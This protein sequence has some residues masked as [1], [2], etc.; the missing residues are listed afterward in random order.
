MTKPVDLVLIGAGQRGARAYAPYALQHPD[1][2]RFVAVA[3]PDPVRRERFAR[4]HGIPPERCFSDWQALLAQ[5]P[6]ADGALIC[7]QDR[8]HEA[9]AV[10]ALQAGYHVL[11]EKPMAPTLAACVRI[12]QA[13]EQSGRHLQVCHVMRYADFYRQLQRVVQ[14]GRLGEVITVDHRENVG[15]W[16]MAHSFVRGHWRR[17]D[18]SSPMI[19]AKCCHDLDLLYWTLGRPCRRLSAFGGLRHFRADQV[20]PE[21]PER[22]SDGCP[23]ERECPFSAIAIYVEGRPFRA[24]DDAGPP[25][26]YGPDRPPPWPVPVI[27]DDWSVAGR[28][29]AIRN[30]PWGRCV[31]RCD[32]DVVDHHVIAMEFDGGVSAT[33][34]MH[35]HSHEDYRS[36]R[37]DG[38]RATLR[39]RFGETAEMTVH[40]HAS[41]RVEPVLFEGAGDGHGG[42]D[43]GVMQSFARVLRGEEQPLTNARASLESHLMA[44]AAEA[45]RTSGEVVDL[46]DFR[47]QAEAAARGGSGM[48]SV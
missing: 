33:F 43:Q 1:Q 5:G 8:H 28:W 38:T 7:T 11:L 13:S 36:I 32:N 12:V 26:D 48:D 45:S 42:G 2:A 41:G 6:I 31:Y 14:S 39:A 16:H 20:G 22:C 15:Y 4:E 30:G 40:D 34:A 21:I 3:E 25:V 47:A 44:F 19:L 10:A 37:Y 29:N 23:I 9:P 18:E 35:G 46:S 17:T 24:P 27:S